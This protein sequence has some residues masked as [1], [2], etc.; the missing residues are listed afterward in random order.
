MKIPAIFDLVCQKLKQLLP[1]DGW[2]LFGT[3]D[4]TSQ[5]GEN[6][7]ESLTVHWLDDYYKPQ[8]AVLAVSEIVGH[9]TAEN[10][11]K[12]FRDNLAFW[13]TDETSV[14]TVV[15]D[16]GANIVKVC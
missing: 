9:H 8:S 4:W 15:T 10:I 6:S 14:H 16:S 3:D 11:L 12:L 7:F 2:L 1:T 13:S 5:N